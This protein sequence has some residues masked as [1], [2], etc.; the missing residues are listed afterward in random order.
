MDAY[1]DC[2]LEREEDNKIERYFTGNGRE[3]SKARRTED[4]NHPQNPIARVPS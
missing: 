3:V 4:K 1:R 2:Y